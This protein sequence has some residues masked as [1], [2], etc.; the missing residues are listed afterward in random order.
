MDGRDIILAGR[1]YRVTYNYYVKVDYENEKRQDVFFIVPIET[2][3]NHNS[4]TFKAIVLQGADHYE[5][6]D[7]V[8]GGIFDFNTRGNRYDYNIFEYEL[9]ND[10]VFS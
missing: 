1:V 10:L 8:Y 2:A 3:C 6:R 7:Y 9:I 5:L 4:K